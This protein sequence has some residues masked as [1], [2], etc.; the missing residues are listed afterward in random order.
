LRIYY[1]KPQTTDNSKQQI[2]QI[3]TNCRNILPICQI[4]LSGWGW[5]TELGAGSGHFIRLK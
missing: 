2:T 4:R 3:Q 1:L 5:N